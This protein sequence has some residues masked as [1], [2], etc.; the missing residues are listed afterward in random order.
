MAQHR[1]FHKHQK[2]WQLSV[3]I[4]GANS[5]G[6]V[7][8]PTKSDE[9][10]KNSLLC[11]ISDL[12]LELEETLCYEIFKMNETV[13]SNLSCFCDFCSDF[14]LVLLLLFLLHHR[15]KPDAVCLSRP[16]RATQTKRISP[17]W[18]PRSRRVSQHKI[19]PNK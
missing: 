17:W 14:Q 19:H 10:L 1:K 11:F 4:R 6:G 16:G 13:G 5:N 8:H 7:Q 2:G 12:K 3:Q 15:L 9:Q 18:V